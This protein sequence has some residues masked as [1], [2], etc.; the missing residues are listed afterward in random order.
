MP[1]CKLSSCV[2]V[3]RT[4]KGKT[5]ETE[6]RF[7]FSVLPESKGEEKPNHNL[8]TVNKKIYKGGYLQNKQ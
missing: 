2:L 3:I 6:N 7:L 1:C 5:D 4:S 8:V